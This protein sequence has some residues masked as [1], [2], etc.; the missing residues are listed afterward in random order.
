MFSCSTKN[1]EYFAGAKCNLYRL[2]C[3][4]VQTKNKEYFAGATPTGVAFSSRK[5]AK[6]NLHRLLC[7]L[8]R[9]KIKSILRERQ[10]P[11]RQSADGT[12][13]EWWV[14]PRT[15]I[16]LWE[17]PT[18]VAFSSWKI[19]KYNIYRLLCFLVRL[20]IKSILRERQHPRRQSSDGTPREWWVLPEPTF[21]SGKYPQG[22]HFPPGK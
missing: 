5:I 17:I 18:G 14:L 6:C 4:L 8:V 2:L 22:S 12:P 20:K 13:R 19:V 3:F 15:Y 7:F 16:S 11:R 10:H 21:P 1:K 9:L